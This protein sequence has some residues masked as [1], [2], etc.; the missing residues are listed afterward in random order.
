MPL[1]GTLSR[2]HGSRRR[3]RP[4]LLTRRRRCRQSMFL[5]EPFLHDLLHCFALLVWRLDG[6]RRQYRRNGRTNSRWRRNDSSTLWRELRLLWLRWLRRSR[7]SWLCG[8]RLLGFGRRCWNRRSCRRR[9]RSGRWRCHLHFNRWR[10]LLNFRL[11][12]RFGFDF[13]SRRF[14]FDWNRFGWDF[15]GLNLIRHFNGNNVVATSRNFFV[16]IRHK[17][18]EFPAQFVC[19]TIF[20]RIRMRCYRHTHVLQ[21]ANDF[22][23]IAIELSG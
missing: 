21:F 22:R 4:A 3:V 11:D 9:W 23:V 18:T 13:N 15:Y 19:Q 6:L 10:L 8:G 17:H 14:G 5:A 7:L 20:N 16:G 1:S 2:G 12:L